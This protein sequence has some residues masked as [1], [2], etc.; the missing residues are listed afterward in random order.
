MEKVQRFVIHI[1]GHYQHG[2]ETG[3]PFS[4]WYKHADNENGFTTVNQKTK[5]TVFYGRDV[6]F[7]ALSKVAALDG[8]EGGA[9]RTYGR[10]VDVL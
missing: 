3:T 9:V 8:V 2:S 10:E 6:V 1:K 7:D 4:G 5:A